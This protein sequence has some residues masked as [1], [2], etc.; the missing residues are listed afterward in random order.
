MHLGINKRSNFFAVAI[1]VTTT[2]G[3]VAAEDDASGIAFF[4]KNIRPVLTNNC[5]RCHSA[6]A[7]Q[8]KGELLLDSKEGVLD[9]GESG[10]VVVP[11]QPGQSRL[12][13]AIRRSGK[14][15][16]PPKGKLPKRVVANFSRWIKM[17]APD[18][19]STKQVNLAKP[20]IDFDESRKFW[21]FIKPIRPSVPK[22]SDTAWPR[23]EIDHFV[24]AKLEQKKLTPVRDARR[25]ELIRRACFDLTGLPPTPEQVAAFLGDTSEGAFEKVIDELLKSPHFGEQWGRHWL[26]IARYSESNGMERNY[27]YP[28]AWRYRD[29]VIESFNRDKP[30]DQF[31]R[32][33]VAG[34]LLG[35]GNPTDEQLIATGF[36]AI[37][38]KPLNQGNDRLF[39]LE[40]IDEQIDATTRAFLGLTVA[41]ARCHDHK[42]DPI[43]T[44]DYYAMAGI[45]RSTTTLYGTTNTQGNR[46]PSDLHTVTGSE[47]NRSNKIQEHNDKLY[48]LNGSL[49]V[50]Q[51]EMRELREK[52]RRTTGNK[53]ARIRKLNRDI[54]DTRENI[55]YLEKKKPGA[56]Y[57]MGVRDGK[58]SDAR[59]LIHGEIRNLGS[60][61]KRGFPQVLGHVKSK[62]IGNESSG[63]L[64]LADW[65]AQADNP[66]TARVMVNRIWKH[67]LGSALVRSTDNFGATGMTPTHPAL[68]D[69]LALH[70]T[71][72]GWSVKA[73]IKDLMLSRTYQLS[74]DTNDSNTAIDPGNRMLWRMSHKRLGA[75]A[76]RDAMLATS[77]EL[78][79]RPS[80]RSIVS[81]LGDMDVS[82]A[83]RQLG[84]FQRKTSDRRSIY[85]PVM[86]NA[87]PE[88][89]RI[90]DAAEPSLIVGRRNETTVPTQALYLMNNSFVIG[91]AYN[92][93]Q[94][95]MAGAED[96]PAGIRLAYRLAFA[97]E[98][99][100]NEVSRAR[101]FIASVGEE[102]DRPGQW[103]TLCQALL[104]SAEFRYID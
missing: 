101:E 27:T 57:A 51:E 26:D 104:A 7:R 25:R 86:R 76:L 68:L 84:Q 35:Q 43:P 55:E 21:S 71:D 23:S 37:G 79:L 94:R 83:L 12:L 87:Q 92:M 52:G 61:V 97:R 77:G 82:R 53:A 65:I 89:M 8:L 6:D 20:S 69:H 62:P 47:G 85:L 28:H 18:P 54:R 2:L 74:S 38:P 96:E 11:G 46:Q 93:A 64:Q 1:A 66:L 102:K 33:Q 32:E 16:M 70:F 9:G 29:Y 49:V 34:D 17:G 45:F 78:N 81:E 95:V 91:Q 41:C 22:V 36:L 90:F 73:L 50:M 63:R 48:R 67:L 60:A 3:P 39:S 88:M 14:L 15:K 99:T 80:D 42:F 19:R 75:E 10:P 59:V 58:V 100:D 24:L 30:F 103:T 72:N 4:E 31:V 44:E 40:V 98:A 13:Q 5:Y 56:D